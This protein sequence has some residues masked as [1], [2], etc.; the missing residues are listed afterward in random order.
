MNTTL[1]HAKEMIPHLL[2]ANIVPFMHSSP[3][4]G[5]SSVGFQISEQY[6][7]KFIDLR[8]SDRDPSDM[9]GLPSFKDGKAS[10][11]PFDTFPLEDTPIPEGYKG[12]LIMLK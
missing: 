3:G 12:W 4:I 11:L 7:L 1:N 5:K 8:L 9:N 2:G 6:K 10:F